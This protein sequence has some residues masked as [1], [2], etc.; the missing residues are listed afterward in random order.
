[1]LMDLRATVVREVLESRASAEDFDPHAVLPEAQVRELA[2]L[3]TLAPTSY[4]AQNWRIVAVRGA[5]ARQRLL[6]LAYG[7]K[8]VAHASVVFVLFGRID[9][10]PQL[11]ES[12]AR[13]ERWLAAAQRLYAGRPQLQ[14]D[15][16]IRSASLAAMSLMVGAT[17]MG[18]ASCAIIGFDAQGVAQA[19]GQGENDVPVMLVAVGRETGEGTRQKARRP[20]ADVL[21]MR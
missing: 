18:L 17:A 15:E 3:A 13:H 11:E 5:P 2:R 4:N 14:R 21:V 9:I 20:L 8:K 10:E 16:A 1:M 6:E 7:Q 12:P 19:F